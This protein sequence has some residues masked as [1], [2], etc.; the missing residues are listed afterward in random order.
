MT[1]ERV[2]VGFSGGVDSFAAAF[3]LKEAGYEVTAIHL[4]LYDPTPEGTEKH[5]RALTDNLD[6]PLITKDLRDRFRN[7]IIGPFAESYLSGRTPNPCVWC[8]EQIKLQALSEL[9][10]KPGVSRIATGHY[11]KKGFDDT[12]RR[13]FIQRG[14]DRKKDQSYFLS[15]VSQAHLRQL[16]LPLG[17]R[18]KAD[19]LSKIRAEGY[20]VEERPESHDI[21]FLQDTSFAE[22]IT[23]W[24]KPGRKKGTFVNREGKILGTHEGFYRFTIGQRRGIG[25]ADRTPYYVTALFPEKNQV[26]IGKA[27][28]L[29]RST[30]RVTDCHWHLPPDD[31]TLNIHCQIRYRHTAAPAIL[32]VQNPRQG[33]VTFQKPQRAITP[34]QIAAFYQGDSLIG[35]GVIDTVS[36]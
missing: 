28:D 3:L 16:L 13:W 23:S 36:E 4:I 5:L 8:N 31:D 11:A 9:A 7:T 33:E 2:F 34:G 35:A 25:I 22:F 6:I 1:K 26:R 21:C 30:F 14:R 17:D 27:E 19:L 20:P 10:E 18:I 24:A 12:R 29:Y 32:K 15:F